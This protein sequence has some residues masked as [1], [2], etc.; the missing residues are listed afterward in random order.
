MRT[1]A[2]LVLLFAT[3]LLVGACGKYGPPIRAMGSGTAGPASRPSSSIDVFDAALEDSVVVE[4]VSGGE[5]E[6]QEDPV[7]GEPEPAEGNPAEE[8]PEG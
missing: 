6:F 4:E 8:E 7:E 1:Q 3:A 2:G 5:Q